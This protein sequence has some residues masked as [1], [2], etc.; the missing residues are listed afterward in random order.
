[1][2]SAEK[3][4]VELEDDEVQCFTYTLGVEE[5]NAY[6]D[7]VENGVFDKLNDFREKYGVRKSQLYYRGLYL[8]DETSKIYNEYTRNSDASQAIHSFMASQMPYYSINSFVCS[9]DNPEVVVETF[10]ASSV[11]KSIVLRADYNLSVG[12]YGNRWVIGM[13]L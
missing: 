3:K 1:M 7:S 11:N 13:I 6:F 9:S 10:L 8:A 5:Y 2:L 4:S 12:H